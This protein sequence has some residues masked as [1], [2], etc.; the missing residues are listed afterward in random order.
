MDGGVSCLGHPVTRT[1]AWHSQPQCNIYVRNENWVG[2][3]E[4]TKSAK[5]GTHQT[6]S[7]Y[8]ITFSIMTKGSWSWDCHR[9]I[10]QTMSYLVTVTAS[11]SL[12]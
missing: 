8:S 9:K 11:L 4:N 7:R 1:T 10:Q 12:A 3:G 5:T 6:P 2:G